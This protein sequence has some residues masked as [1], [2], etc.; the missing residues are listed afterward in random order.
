MWGT[1]LGVW[2][3]ARKRGQKLK[4]R[5]HFDCVACCPPGLVANLLHCMSACPAGV[6]CLCEQKLQEAET[7]T[8]HSEQQTRDR[9]RG[10]EY[11]R[12]RHRSTPGGR[13]RRHRGMCEQKQKPGN[14]HTRTRE[15]EADTGPVPRYTYCMIDIRILP[16]WHEHGGAEE[17]WS[18]CSAHAPSMVRCT[19]LR[20]VCGG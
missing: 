14:T 20:S 5:S 2:Q 18:V 8:T 3:S 6:V 16:F 9:A 17:E 13:G 10:G 1:S 7:D 15:S 19:R 4:I 12:Q 11:K